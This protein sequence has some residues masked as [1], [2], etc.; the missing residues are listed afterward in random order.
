[1]HF[2]SVIAGFGGQGVLLTGQIIAYAGLMEDKHVS[3]IPSYG[4]EM[5]GGT[6]NCSV[7][8]SDNKIG[9]PMVEEPGVALIF[10]EPSMEKFEQQVRPGGIMVVNSSIVEKK[11]SRKDI[12][13]YDIPAGKIAKQ[14]G[15]ERVANMVMLGAYLEL[16]GVVST[17]S[18]INALGKIISKK[19]QSILEI[20]KKAAEIGASVAAGYSVDSLLG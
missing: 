18:A 8:V 16:T 2:E 12:H 3:W 17:E 19:K 7:I 15:N 20:N 13:V 4:P 1:M 11:V 14:L 10:N 9:S 5:R 6:A